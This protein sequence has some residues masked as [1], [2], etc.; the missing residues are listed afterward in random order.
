MKDFTPVIK[1]ADF[2]GIS[3]G[4]L[5]RLRDENVLRF[6]KNHFVLLF[7]KEGERKR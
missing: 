6:D 4:E 7:A 3:E 1:S 2:S 5:G